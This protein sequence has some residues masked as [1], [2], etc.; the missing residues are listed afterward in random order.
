MVKSIILTIL[1]T[2]SVFTFAEVIT[3]NS[4]YRVP[5]NTQWE[6]NNITT[7]KCNVCTSD[8]Y[9]KNGSIKVNNVWINGSFELSLNGVNELIIDEGTTFTLGDSR[10]ELNIEKIRL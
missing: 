9:I 5:K 3:N 2:V 4:L 7:A 10:P 6:V 1:L 8:I